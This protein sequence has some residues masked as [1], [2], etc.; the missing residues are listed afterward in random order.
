VFARLDN[1]FL[2][3]AR[4]S[5]SSSGAACLLALIYSGKLSIANL[6]DCVATLISKEGRI[7]KLSVEQDLNRPD[8]IKRIAN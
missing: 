2:E 8:E 4:A 5:G 3:T 6:G 7:N 1:K